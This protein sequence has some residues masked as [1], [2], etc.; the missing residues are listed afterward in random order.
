MGLKILDRLQAKAK[1]AHRH[2]ALG[3]AIDERMLR[4]A[5]I[6]T[7]AKLA[8]LTLLG[9]T[10]EVQ[11][12]AKVLGISITGI[13]I[14]NASSFSAL[15]KLIASY[16]KSRKPKEG[17]VFDPEKEIREHH[18]LFGALL[19]R[20]GFVDGVLG[21]SLSTTGDVIRGALRGIGTRRGISVLSSLFLMCFGKIDG[22]RE[23]EFVLGFGDCSVIPD[24]TAEQ[25]ADIAIA[26]AATYERLTGNTPHIAMLSFSTKGSA[27]TNS[28]EKVIAATAFVRERE[29]SLIIDGEL[30]FDA[31]FVPSIAKRKSKDSPIQGD[32]NVFIFPNLDAGNISYKIAE[33]LGM[34]EAVGPV[35]QGLNKPMNDLSRGA[36]VEDIVNMIAITALQV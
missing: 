16:Q 25:L 21:G 28:T 14:M 31:A 29:P 12:V 35:L 30:Q 4:A 10:T 7:D 20:E 27:H 34:G 19:A 8:K 33:R 24:P 6:A 18:L 3:D 5:R 17:E 22:V 32:A 26:G 23:E 1:Q 9:E 15:D 13:E 36:S 11:S 2:I